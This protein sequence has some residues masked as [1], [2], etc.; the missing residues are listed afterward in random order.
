MTNIEMFR[1]SNKGKA[2]QYEFVIFQVIFSFFYEQYL[3]YVSY[4]LDA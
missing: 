2:V 4:K 1:L 3:F